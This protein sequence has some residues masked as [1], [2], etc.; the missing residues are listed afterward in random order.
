MKYHKDVDSWRYTFTRLK[1]NLKFTV[2]E[3]VLKAN[4]TEH[5]AY[6]QTEVIKRMLSFLLCI[7]A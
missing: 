6:L 5:F 2:F 7:M 3:T 1:M 4:K